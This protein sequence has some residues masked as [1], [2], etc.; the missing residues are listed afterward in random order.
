MKKEQ[1]FRPAPQNEFERRIRRKLGVS[2]AAARA[3]SELMY[4]GKA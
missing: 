4:L 1:R 3:I 2:P